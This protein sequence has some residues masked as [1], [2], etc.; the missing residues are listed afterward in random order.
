MCLLCNIYLLLHS[1]FCFQ[2]YLRFRLPLNRL[3]LGQTLVI[4]AVLVHFLCV[5]GRRE[6][7][8]EFS[9]FGSC[10]LRIH[11][12]LGEAGRCNFVW[13]L[14]CLQSCCN[15]EK[16]TLLFFE[17][18]LSFIFTS[19]LFYFLLRINFSMKKLAYC[20]LKLAISHC[21]PFVKIIYFWAQDHNVRIKTWI[22]RAV[23]N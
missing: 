23:F 16:I 9:L 15:F 19:Y 5:W 6:N 17:I 8:S 20:L 12:M 1:L 21:L 22:V 4:L 3:Y 10:Y 2:V 14:Q 13:N 18:Q 7:L 11:W